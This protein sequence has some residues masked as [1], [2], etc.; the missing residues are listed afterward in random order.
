MFKTLRGRRRGFV[1]MGVALGISAMVVSVALPA[2]AAVSPAANNT[3]INAGSNT[4]YQMMAQLSALFG[5]VPGCDLVPAS[6]TQNLD[7][8]CPSN[9]GETNGA[10]TPGGEN[11]YTLSYPSPNPYNDVSVTEPAFGS[12][13]GIDQ[14][15]YQG[16]DIPSSNTP[17][18]APISFARSSR[19]ASTTSGTGDK[20]GLNFVAYAQD[21]VPWFHFTK[22]KGKKTPSAK[23]TNLSTTTLT[24]I[25]DGSI[26]NWDNS[27]IGGTNAPIYVYIAQSSSGTFSTWDTDLD[28]GPK[29]N[30]PYDGV[31][32]SGTGD[33]STGCPA[34]DFEIFENEDS[35]ILSPSCSKA[36]AADAIFF[37]SYGKFT[38]LCP[39]GVCEGSSK[40]TVAALGE[41]GG[42]AASPATIQAQSSGSGTVFPLDRYL[43]NVYSNGTNSNL[44]AA[45]QPV[46]NFIST[47]GFLCNPQ[48]KT[49]VDPLSSTGATY[50]TEI[51][52]IISEEG[53]FPITLGPEGDTATGV[54]PPSFTDPNYSAAD[55][56]PSGDSGYCR[57]TTT[58]GDGNS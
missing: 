38:L 33:A 39:K 55:P 5:Q 2:G 56:A 10:P 17:I 24:G 6:G 22:V 13:G 27:A 18:V 34:S 19:A 4:T 47:Y 11:G 3:L 21:A 14:L 30:Y 36:N 20:S 31:T 48:T 45:S 41:I 9:D 35:Q 58:N 49:E 43:Y 28:L 46:E 29:S 16:A 7:F 53:F 12:S 54:T 42:V 40:T 15:E 44:P 32:G 25:Y 23:V 8:S 51:D 26:T 52:N 37:F 1:G 50:L 57:V